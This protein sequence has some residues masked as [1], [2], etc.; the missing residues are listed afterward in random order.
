MLPQSHV[1][2]Q[3]KEKE[4]EGKNKQK[5][6]ISVQN[7]SSCTDEAPEGQ[8]SLSEGPFRSADIEDKRDQKLQCHSSLNMLNDGN[9]LSFVKQ[10]R[11]MIYLCGGYKGEAGGVF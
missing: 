3:E 7:A 6:P 2:L 11:F 9:V 5:G 10:R 4:E 8:G 1:I